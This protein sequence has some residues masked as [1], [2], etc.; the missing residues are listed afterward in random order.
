MPDLPALSGSE[1]PEEEVTIALES[2][3]AQWVAAT[4]AALSHEADRVI[5][6]KGGRGF[7][8]SQAPTDFQARSTS[9]SYDAPVCVSRPLG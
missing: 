2:A 9:Q 6:G 8:S 1:A 4:Q 3:L 7:I 5:A